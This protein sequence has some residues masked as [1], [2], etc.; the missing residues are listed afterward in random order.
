MRTI[1]NSQFQL[2]KWNHLACCDKRPGETIRA[3]IP[4]SGNLPLEPGLLDVVVEDGLSGL[5][6][7]RVGC[8]TTTET[9]S[10][11]WDTESVAPE[12]TALC[13]GAP[14]ASVLGDPGPVSFH[15]SRS[16]HVFFPCPSYLNPANQSRII[17]VIHNNTIRAKTHAREACLHGMH[18]PPSGRI[19]ILGPI[20]RPECAEWMKHAI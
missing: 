1:L 17:L 3:G 5:S 6:D 14:E 11:L 15:E 16:R 2:F 8:H 7:H 12:G 18:H 13:H 9:D 20:S 19:L 10:L 4:A